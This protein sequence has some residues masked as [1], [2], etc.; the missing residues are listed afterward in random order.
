MFELHEVMSYLFSIGILCS[1]AYLYYFRLPSAPQGPGRYDRED[2]VCRL[3]GAQRLA[4]VRTIGE[5]LVRHMKRKE[6]PDGDSEGCHSSLTATIMR[7]EENDHETK[8][9][10]SHRNTPASAAV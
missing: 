9:W 4:V 8:R 7:N 3:P 5:M 6:A 2:S 10:N 1:F